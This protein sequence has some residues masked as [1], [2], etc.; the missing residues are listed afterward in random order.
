MLF[1]IL[2][3]L[4]GNDPG[5]L[6]LQDKFRTKIWRR[7]IRTILYLLHSDSFYLW[8]DVLHFVLPIIWT[9][10]GLFLKIKELIDFCSW[11]RNESGEA[12]SMSF[13]SS[14]RPV[15]RLINSSNLFKLVKANQ[16]VDNAGELPHSF[17]VCSFCWWDYQIGE[18]VLLMRPGSGLSAFSPR[19]I[20]IWRVCIWDSWFILPV[21]ELKWIILEFLLFVQLLVYFLTYADERGGVF[22]LEHSPSLM[23]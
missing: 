7:L 13:I 3:Y 19:W 10:L 21:I 4:L 6:L 1:H 18:L 8:C 11:R 15:N 20:S 12:A 9:G 14:C 16:Y 23:R 2:L 22:R 17:I 5:L